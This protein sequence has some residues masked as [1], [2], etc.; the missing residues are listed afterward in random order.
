MNLFPIFDLF[1]TKLC[2]RIVRKTSVGSSCKWTEIIG[3]SKF[4]AELHIQLPLQHLQNFINAQPS[5]VCFFN[6]D[7]FCSSER[8]PWII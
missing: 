4:S 5:H 7:G 1:I 8:L 2:R 3:R 6:F